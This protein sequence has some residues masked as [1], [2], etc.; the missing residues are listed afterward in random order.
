[1]RVRLHWGYGDRYEDEIHLEGKAKKRLFTYR[2][3][4][5]FLWSPLLVVLLVMFWQAG[6]NWPLLERLVDR[7]LGIR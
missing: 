2:V 6:S 3:K 1:M 5:F 7:I 4:V